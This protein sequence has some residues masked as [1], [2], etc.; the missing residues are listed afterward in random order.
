MLKKVNDKNLKKVHIVMGI[1]DD[2]IVKMPFISY[3]IS[4]IDSDKNDVQVFIEYM[5]KNGWLFHKRNGAEMSFKKED[6]ILSVLNRHIKTVI[7]DNK[8]VI[9]KTI[10]NRYKN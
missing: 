2:K 8:I 4:K 1:R 6:K 3:Y 5:S 9:F 7:V 10:L